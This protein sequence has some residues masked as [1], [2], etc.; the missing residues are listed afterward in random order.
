MYASKGGDDDG[1][2]PF[3]LSPLFLP[4]FGGSRV[5]ANVLSLQ[6]WET[7]GV[8]LHQRERQPCR[9]L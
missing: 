9:A 6:D 4:F 8:S 1:A 3:L 7:D 2:L 5:C